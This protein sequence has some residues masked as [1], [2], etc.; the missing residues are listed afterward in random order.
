MIEKEYKKCP[1]CGMLME[2]DG[3]LWWNS[4]LTKCYFAFNCPKCGAIFKHRLSKEEEV[5][6]KPTEKDFFMQERMV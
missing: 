2:R 3:H 5:E 6:L 1:D 4:D